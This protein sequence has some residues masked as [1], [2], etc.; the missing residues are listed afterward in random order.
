MRR[1]RI[2]PTRI[3]WILLW[4]AVL[5]SFLTPV[6]AP[7]DQSDELAIIQSL[8]EQKRIDEAT[9]AFERL[10]EKYPQAEKLPAIYLA[11]ARLPQSLFLRKVRLRSVRNRYPLSEQAASALFELIELDFLSGDFRET[12]RG[13]QD[14]LRSHPADERSAAIRRFYVHALMA[15]R[16]FDMARDLLDRI[17]E[18]KL[19]TADLILKHWIMA[20]IMLLENKPKRSRIHLEQAL[21]TGAGDQAGIAFRLGEVALLQGQAETAGRYFQIVLDRYA[22]SPYFIKSGKLLRSLRNQEL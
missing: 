10:A 21:Q 2:R 9:A 15:R 4:S 12:I 13:A 7:A 19:S 22:D 1:T 14:F 8:I 5:L 6:R 17:E 11:L 18:K 20:E 3:L 16:Q